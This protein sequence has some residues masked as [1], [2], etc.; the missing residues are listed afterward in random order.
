MSDIVFI[1][2][3]GASRLAGAPLMDDFL[4]TAEL[5][6]RADKCGNEKTAFELVFKAIAALQPVYAKAVIDTNNL[7]AVFAAFEMAKLFGQLEGLGAQE[8]E[9]LPGAIRKV[10]VKTL[11]ET[12][13][14]PVFAEEGG[15]RSILAPQPYDRFCDVLKTMTS[16]PNRPATVSVLT[17][18]YDLAVDFGFHREGV[19]IN[20]GLDPSDTSG[21]I[22]LLKLHGSLN[23]STCRNCGVVAPWTL[24]E[25]FN[26]FDYNPL[27]LDAG[28]VRL[29]VGQKLTAF[30]HCGALPHTAEPVI[31]PPTWSKTSHYEVL[32]PVWRR[33]A[34]H[35]AQA[36]DI[37]IIGY[38]LPDTDEFFRYLYALGSASTQRL[39]TFWVIDPDDTGR[40]RQRFE[41]LLGPL[42]RSRFMVHQRTFGEMVGLIAT[43]YARAD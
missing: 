24:R 1:L 3:A 27:L 22:D 30:A 31:V 42:A 15:R 32:A 25:F 10:I 19:T 29:D 12:I 36:R 18:N 4:D 20:Y 34:A 8:L 9:A 26:V 43:T 11:E 21:R 38:S 16:R 39:K 41:S 28:S 13:V 5:I 7:E 6:L 2:G 23:W 33:A 14:F 37:I 17:F 35:L 40:V